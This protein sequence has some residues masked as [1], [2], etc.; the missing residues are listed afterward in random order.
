MCSSDLCGE[1]EERALLRVLA[2]SAWDLRTDA[3]QAG[4]ALRQLR[5]FAATVRRASEIFAAPRLR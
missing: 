1:T 2:D 3:L 5:A 4:E